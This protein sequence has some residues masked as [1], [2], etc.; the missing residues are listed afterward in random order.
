MH[1]H[2]LGGR[3]VVKRGGVLTHV[4]LPA[5]TATLERS[6]EYLYDRMGGAGAF[7]PQPPIDIRCT[8]RA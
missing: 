5:A 3:R 8:E 2:G 7:I 1:R 6:H 4:D